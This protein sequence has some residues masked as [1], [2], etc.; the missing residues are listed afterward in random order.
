MYITKFDQMKEDIELYN[1]KQQRH[2]MEQE[3][4]MMQIKLL[5]T[6]IQNLQLLGQVREKTK[7]DIEDQKA[8]LKK[9]IDTLTNIK[10]ALAL[11]L[12]SLE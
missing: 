10:T 6:E 11:Q 12:S 3:S 8:T 9:Q 5:E 1:K 2:Q 4:K 7:I